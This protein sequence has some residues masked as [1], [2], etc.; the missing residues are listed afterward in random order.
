LR[1]IQLKTIELTQAQFMAAEKAV[2]ECEANIAHLVAIEKS[3]T[4]CLIEPAG[5]NQW[6][7]SS[8]VKPIIQVHVLV[9]KTSGVVV[10]LNWRQAFE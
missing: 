7:I 4:N 9:D 3:E 6:L 5:K 2:L 10:R 1:I 8:K